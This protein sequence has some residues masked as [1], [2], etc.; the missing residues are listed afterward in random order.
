MEIWFKINVGRVLSKRKL[1]QVTGNQ[2]KFH[3]IDELQFG[4]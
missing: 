3:R 1:F 2:E 4:T